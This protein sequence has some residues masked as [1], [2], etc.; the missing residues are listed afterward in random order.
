MRYSALRGV[1]AWLSAVYKSLF[2]A[3]KGF[4]LSQIREMVS[5][6]KSAAIKLSVRREAAGNP[7]L[8]CTPNAIDAT[9]CSIKWL[10]LFYF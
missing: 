3:H 4:Y 6:G 7:R 1:T 10:H 2:A 8:F 5:R 9:G